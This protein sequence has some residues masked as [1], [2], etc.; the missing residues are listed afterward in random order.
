MVGFILQGRRSE[1]KLLAVVALLYEVAPLSEVVPLE[2][3][4]SLYECVLVNLVAVVPEVLR[5]VPQV[6]TAWVV[7]RGTA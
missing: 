6:L 5:A 3:L 1:E 4:L 7:S 2:V